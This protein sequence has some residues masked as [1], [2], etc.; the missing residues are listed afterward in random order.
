M[1]GDAKGKEED[2]KK[3]K[4]NGTQFL[5]SFP[6]HKTLARRGEGGRNHTPT[7]IRPIPVRDVGEDQQQRQ[8]GRHQGER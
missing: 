6:S 7:R 3:E 2:K 5:S 8:Q 1:A 4:G